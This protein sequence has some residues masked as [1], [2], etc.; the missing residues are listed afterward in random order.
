MQPEH[1]VMSL[2][3]NLSEPVTLNEGRLHVEGDEYHPTEAKDT[4]DAKRH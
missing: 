3:E 4:C 2:M 1:E